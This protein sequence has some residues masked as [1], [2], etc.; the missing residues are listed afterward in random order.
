MNTQMA[1]DKMDQ[2]VRLGYVVGR[3]P[4]KMRVRVSLPDTVTSPLVTDWLPV[5][6]RRACEDMEY[7]LPDINDQVLCVFLPIGLEQGFVI[8]SMYGKQSPPVTN[9]DKVHRAFR[10]GTIVEYDR[11]E[12]K[13]TASVQGD[14]V[15]TA[16]GNVAVTGQTIQLNGQSSITMNAPTITIQGTISTSSQGG[17][18]GSVTMNGNVQVNNGDIQADLVSL[19][20]HIHQGVQP[21]GGTSGSPV[22]GG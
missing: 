12:H 20:S 9:P 22:G 8:G 16:T 21:G 10:D 19:K 18:A 14:V 4:D 15:I 11:G 17:G 2:I 1:Q 13:L 7:D 3:Q 5:L 6:C